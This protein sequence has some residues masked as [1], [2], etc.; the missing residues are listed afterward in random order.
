VCEETHG[1]LQVDA[2]W[3]AIEPLNHPLFYLSGPPRML[4]AL[5]AQL[6]GRSVPADDIR[7]DAW[8]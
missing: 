2:A 3:P 6:R 4:A 8:E 1:R 5:T 7:T